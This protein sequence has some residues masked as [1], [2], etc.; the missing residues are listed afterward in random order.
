M[1]RDQVNPSAV[2]RHLP[3]VVWLLL[4]VIVAAGLSLKVYWDLK[5]YRLDQQ[6]QAAVI[7]GEQR[8]NQLEQITQ[9]SNLRGATP[10]Q[11]QAAVGEK[12]AFTL[13][14]IGPDKQTFF[15]EW[16]DPVSNCKFFFYFDQQQRY[17]RGGAPIGLN[18]PRYPVYYTSPTQDDI[19]LA[20]GWLTLNDHEPLI[21]P[22]LVPWV[23]LLIEYRIRRHRRASRSF[24]LAG[25]VVFCVTI[26]LM[27]SDTLL[28]LDGVLDYK[29]NIWGMIM[30]VLTAIVLGVG[31]VSSRVT[32]PFACGGCAYS[33][34][35]NTSGSCPECG[36]SLP[37]WQRKL[38][39]SAGASG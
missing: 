3:I 30:L 19:R 1:S 15:V 5:A 9:G 18:L 12:Q 14:P 13:K 16:T 23:F 28:T 22:A 27:A 20:A 34:R 35:G 31:G 11:V 37:G 8:F 29:P 24:L 2:R 21:P 32:D 10:A 36:R 25:Y 26:W 4:A 39:A 7:A 38:I 17:V 6:R 33:L